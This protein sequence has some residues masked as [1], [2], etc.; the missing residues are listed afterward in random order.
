MRRVLLHLIAGGLGGFLIWLIAE[1]IP[2]L[3][4]DKSY[5]DLAAMSTLG[6][7]LGLGIGGALGAAEG[8][9]RGSVRQAW[10][11]AF[12][13]MGLGLIGGFLGIYIGQSIYGPW[14]NFNEKVLQG[15]ALLPIRFASEIMARTVGWA[16]IGLFVGIASGLLLFSPRRVKSGIVGGL[17]GGALGG[18]CFDIIARLVRPELSR[19]IGFI[20]VGAGTGLGIALA[21][22]F[23]RQAWVRVVM[24]RNE[25]RDYLLEKENNVLGRDEMSD[26]PLFG[27]PSIGKHHAFIARKSG[28][29]FLRDAGSPAGTHVNGQPVKERPLQEG[30]RITIGRFQLEFHSKGGQA[31]PVPERDAVPAPA[32]SP[33]AAANVCAFCGEKKN[34]MTGACACTPLGS[35]AP[36]AAMGGPAAAT[37]SPPPVGAVGG[38]TGTM[39]VGL[40]A[41]SGPYAGR[42]F[43]VSGTASLGRQEENAIALPADT[44]VSRRHATL[45]TSVGGLLRLHDE[46]SSNGTFVNGKP[47][48]DAELRPGDEIQVGGTRLRVEMA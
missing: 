23:A 17:L 41:V 16:F 13:G 5:V 33:V 2:W 35:P 43:P 14:S 47:V 42:R 1:P 21:V 8:L 9:D 38:P 44:A 7:L 45:T 34:P 39:G 36:A 15:T 25:G 4:T 20:C 26:V 29:W 22:Q 31:I 3:T 18:F 12:A 27:D 32:M 28:V 24:G 10:T 40:V 6:A 48:T 37:M 46:G 30:D 11:Y 19:G